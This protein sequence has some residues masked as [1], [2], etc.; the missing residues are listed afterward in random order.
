MTVYIC[1]SLFLSLSLFFF[2]YIYYS[3]NAS[4]A[5][6]LSL[7]SL[8]LRTRVRTP[9]L[10]RRPG[11]WFLRPGLGGGCSCSAAS[12]G[13]NSAGE[14]WPAGHISL[15]HRNYSR[16]V[17]PWGGARAQFTK[18]ENLWLAVLGKS[19][20]VAP[21]TKIEAAGRSLRPLSQFMQIWPVHYVL[22]L[23][24][25]FLQEKSNKKKP[26]QK[27]IK[28]LPTFSVFNTSTFLQYSES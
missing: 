9:G 13:G 4:L 28:Q 2:N 16:T 26:S 18:A 20:P 19:S 11:F 6:W 3:G 24:D 12:V 1:I 10:L 8:N 17:R 15:H 21:L 23:P 14:R 27:L 22:V 25:L 5:R 7:V